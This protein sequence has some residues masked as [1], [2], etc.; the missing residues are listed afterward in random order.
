MFHC[1]LNG[2]LRQLSVFYDEQNFFFLQ[3]GP[4]VRTHLV[5]RRLTPFQM[6]SGGRGEVFWVDG[7]LGDNIILGGPLPPTSLTI[8]AAQR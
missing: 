5:R 8:E 2:K 6:I 1:Y 4:Y 7:G 3:G